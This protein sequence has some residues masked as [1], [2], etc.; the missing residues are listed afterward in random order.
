MKYIALF[1][2]LLA[3]AQFATAIKIKH[4][5][6]RNGFQ[7]TLTKIENNQEALRAIIS[8]PTAISNFWEP[9]YQE[10]D[11][12][13]NGLDREEFH[14]AYLSIM[15]R[16][17]LP[18]YPKYVTDAVFDSYNTN[19]DGYIQIS[20]AEAAT[21]VLVNY[22]VGALER[23]RFLLIQRE[24]E[25]AK[26]LY[27][28][29]VKASVKANV[30]NPVIYEQLADELFQRLFLEADGAVQRPEILKAIDV[31]TQRWAYPR[32]PENIVNEIV[33]GDSF[34]RDDVVAIFRNIEHAYLSVC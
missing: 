25:Q 17:D 34:S 32:L 11:P 33:V 10:F 8:D 19:G 20:E 26:P 27:C 18:Q 9:I 29:S 15:S 13:H 23:H 22:V 7:E 1:L 5:S 4:R 6:K 28:K 31:Y 30:K 21:P 3:V 12:D 2:C 14:R 16:Y 24:L